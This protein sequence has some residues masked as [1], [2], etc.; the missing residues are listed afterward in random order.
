MLLFSVL[1]ALGSMLIQHLF[2]HN[3][4]LILTNKDVCGHE[5]LCKEFFML[6]RLG[7]FSGWNIKGRSSCK[8]QAVNKLHY[9]HN[10]TNKNI[11][12]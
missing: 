12:K 1:K 3:Y 2:H 6:K 5:M 8:I 7:V 4:C 11:V 9:Y 10:Q